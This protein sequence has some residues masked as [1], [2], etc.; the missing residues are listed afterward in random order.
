MGTRW[1]ELDKNQPVIP[2][3]HSGKRSATV[4]DALNQTGFTA[5]IM[6]GGMIKWQQAGLPIH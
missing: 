3:C 5:D 6:T 4:V 1:D 2:V